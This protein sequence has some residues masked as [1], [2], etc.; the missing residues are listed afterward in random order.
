MPLKEFDDT[1]SFG[2]SGFGVKCKSPSR[3]QTVP[4]V[5][6][7]QVVSDTLVKR[8]FRFLIPL[9]SKIVGF[10]FGFSSSLLAV[11][12]TDPFPGRE[13]K[14][15]PKQKRWKMED[16]LRGNEPM[17]SLSAY[18]FLFLRIS[19]ERH[20]LV[21][22]RLR[23]YKYIDEHLH[24]FRLSSFFFFFLF[25]LSVLLLPVLCDDMIPIHFLF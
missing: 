14:E 9:L 22:C 6:K 23:V 12:L 4:K 13:N 17:S 24:L 11:Y 19:T 15:A 20:T 5:M 18:L 16:S 1:T 3:Q 10:L 2:F 21:D 8:P 25:V 7:D